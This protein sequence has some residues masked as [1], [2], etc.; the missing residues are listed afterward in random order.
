MHLHV[1][2][3]CVCVWLYVQNDISFSLVRI[4][5]LVVIRKKIDVC[6]SERLP[7]F[8]FLFGCLANPKDHI[9]I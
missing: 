6:V 9:A 4:S 1:Y 3:V 8:Q 5:R 2:L 7:L